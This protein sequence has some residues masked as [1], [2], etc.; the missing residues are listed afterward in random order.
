MVGTA[1]R[2]REYPQRLR[3]VRLE[4]AERVDVVGCVY[5]MTV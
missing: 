5:F 2:Q 3:R 1:V 4:M